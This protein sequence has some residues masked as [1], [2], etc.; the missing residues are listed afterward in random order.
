MK[1]AGQPSCKIK[2]LYYYTISNDLRHEIIGLK[3]KIFVV[4]KIALRLYF[5]DFRSVHFYYFFIDLY[6]NE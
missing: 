6:E 2:C 4:E 3:P 1:L 5:N